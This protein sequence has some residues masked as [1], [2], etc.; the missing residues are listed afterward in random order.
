[1]QPIDPDDPR[2]PYVKIAASIRAAILAD[3]FKPDEQLPTGAEL[4][5]TFGVQR[6]AIVSAVRILREEGYVRSTPGGGYYVNSP[7]ALPVVNGQRHEWAAVPRFLFEAGHLKNVPRSGW[8]L[9]GIKNAETIAE[10]SFRVTLIGVILATLEGADPGRTAALCVMHDLHETRIMDLPNVVRAYVR[11]DPPQRVTQDQTAAMPDDVAALL[12]EITSEYENKNA[13]TLESAV[14]HDADKL[15]TLI[16][17]IEYEAKGYAT[18]P[19]QATSIE[20]LRTKSGKHLADAIRAAD[21]HEWWRGHAAS[22]HELRATT[23]A[24]QDQADEL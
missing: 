24:R 12:R 3:E 18:G 7:A 23:R 5:Q 19:W 2:A 9:L 1:M 4:A 14:A 16:Q 10:H 13:L 20:S 22:Y 15:E 17:A 6:G 11:T 8:L 21:P